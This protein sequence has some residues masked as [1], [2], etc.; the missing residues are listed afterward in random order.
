[1]PFDL[2]YRP[3]GDAVLQRLRQLYVDRSPQVVLAVMDTP[4]EALRQFAAS[5]PDGPCEYPDPAERIAFWDAR[6]AERA[7]IED[8]S[9]PCAYPSELDQG[10]YGAL[11]GAEPR[12]LSSADM[13]WISSMVAPFLDDLAEV[14]GLSIDR[15][16]EWQQRYVEQL[17]VFVEGA[18]GKFGISHFILI[19]GLNLIFE[20]VGATQTYMELIERPELVRKAIALAHELNVHVQRTFFEHVPLVAGGTC[21]F[22]AQWLP[23]RII[24]E[25]VDPFHMTSVEYFE[26]WGRDVLE[27]MFGEF[28]GG[29]LHVHGNGRHLLEAVASVRGV[30]AL[31]VGDDRGFAKAFD[32]LDE[33][34]AR[35]GDLPLIVGVPYASFAAALAERRLVGGVLY[36]VS[37]VLDIATANR[38]MER[39]RAYAARVAMA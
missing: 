19:N 32:V 11:L 35:V 36:T 12:F 17:R 1:M 3:T 16:G 26:Q 23:G 2:S 29:I 9:I 8:D 21:S 30:K 4:S 13:G 18:A 6:L 7:A 22:P 25:S 5:H 33:V 28:D 10:L 37:D 38:C 27:R 20:L 14:G 24:S 15:N 31:S 34:R 39:V